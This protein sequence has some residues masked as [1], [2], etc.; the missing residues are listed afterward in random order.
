MAPWRCMPAVVVAVALSCWSAATLLSGMA[1]AERPPS[2]RLGVADLAERL[3]TG[4]RVKA[5]RDE[6]FCESVA[7]RV[8]E[9]R[10]PA[11]LV[12][13]TYTWSLERGKKYPFPAFEHVL[14]MKADRLGVPLDASPLPRPGGPP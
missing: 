13:A 8:G 10:L 3:K 14:R 9:G 7:R 11:D 6:A 12:D 4:L 2:A 1:L 5:P